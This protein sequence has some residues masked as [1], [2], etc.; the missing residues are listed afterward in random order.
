MKR[1]ILFIIGLVCLVHC[2]ILEHPKTPVEYE[3]EWAIHINKGTDPSSLEELGFEVLGLI[4]TLDDVYLVRHKETHARHLRSTAHKF[5]PSIDITET[6]TKHSHVKWAE[7]Q[8]LTKQHTR[9]VT[10][11]LFTSQWHLLN[12]GQFSGAVGI[13]ANIQ[14]AWD[15]GYFGQG[16]RIAIVDDGF[17]T[18]HPDLSPGYKADSSVSFNAPAGNSP[19]PDTTS[20]FHGT[21]AAGVALASNNSVCGVGAAYMAQG[22]GIRLIAAA[23]TDATTANGISYRNQLNHIYSNSW[24]PQDNGIDVGGPGQASRAALANSVAQGRNGLGSIYLWAAGNGLQQ[25]DN[26]NYDGWA[27][28]RETIAV[29]AIGNDGKQAYYSE[30]CA[31]MLITAP[32]SSANPN[33]G[34]RTSDLVD[35]PGYDPSSC[36]PSFGGTSSACPLVA[37]ITALVL[38]ANPALTWRDVP[39]ILAKTAAK[40]D[41][42]DTDWA[43]NG[44]GFHVNHKYGFGMIDATAAVNAAKAHKNLSPQQTATSNVV[45]VN[46]PIPDYTV[47]GVGVSSTFTIASS[48]TVEKVLITVNINHPTSGDL[49]IILTSPS[50]TE[51][52]LSTPHAFVESVVTPN[53][54]FAMAPAPYGPLLNFT[55]IAGTGLRAA[56]ITGCTALTN[57]AAIA[58]KIAIVNTGTCASTVKTKAAQV[59]GAIAVIILSTSTASPDGILRLDGTDPTATIPTFSASYNGGLGLANN[60]AATIKFTQYS[61]NNY[62]NGWQMSSVR[63][64]GES[65]AGT[66]KV[67]VTDGVPGNVGT[68]NSY[69]VTVYGS[70]TRISPSSPASAVQICLLVPLLALL[71]SLLV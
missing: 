14:G 11:P 28:S 41:D 45:T 1:T 4:S 25:N 16:I 27:T 22:A 48:I 63:L 51:S 47:N 43:T 18:Y 38:Q 58:G 13:D 65:S 57:C 44:A 52:Y 31:A 21:A 2:D 59:C 35:G 50:G 64:L 3:S 23:T 46:T 29:G 60:A 32:S 62:A 30:P 67:R 56:P 26:C 69:S 19:N 6:L 42:T 17:Q 71:L 34:I 39:V 7:Q 20:D 33:A 40:V 55:P 10:D 15:Q 70:D 36:A 53:T 54:V 49:E 37:G 24:G 66:W 68:F 5:V 9:A 61:A 12:T 8:F